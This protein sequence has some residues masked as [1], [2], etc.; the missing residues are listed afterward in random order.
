ML[1]RALRWPTPKPA[2]W[3]VD[4]AAD[5]FADRCGV[6]CWSEVSRDDLVLLQPGLAGSHRFGIGVAAVLQQ[7]VDERTIAASRLIDG[8]QIAAVSAPAKAAAAWRLPAD[9]TGGGWTTGSSRCRLVASAL[10]DPWLLEAASRE[11][12]VT[13]HY[14]IVRAIAVLLAG[15]TDPG[16]ARSIT[17]AEAALASLYSGVNAAFVADEL[18]YAHELFSVAAWLG[19]I[20]R[21]R[22]AYVPVVLAERLADELVTRDQC[23][24]ACGA[25]R[26]VRWHLSALDARSRL[27]GPVQRTLRTGYPALCKGADVDPLIRL[28][29]RRRC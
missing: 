10:P 27:Q 29:A 4:T 24:G 2:P 15:A 6:T 25:T 14:E 26:L 21:G 18:A 8:A 9:H 28:A 19:H 22:A 20:V 23:P 16:R 13:F 5:S 1:A 11:G 3:G 7:I 17:P 12:L